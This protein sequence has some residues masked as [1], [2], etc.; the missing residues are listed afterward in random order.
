ME[1]IQVFMEEDSVLTSDIET[2]VIATQQ[3]EEDTLHRWKNAHHLTTDGNGL[4][5][6][7]GALVVVGNNDLRRGV[8]RLFHD[9]TTAGHPGITKTTQLISEYY[10]WPGMKDFITHYIKGCATCQ[11]SKV[12]THPNK[13]QIS[14]VTATP[15]ALPFETVAMDFIVKL[16]ESEG[17][18]TILTITD[19]DCTKAAIFIPCNETIDTPELAKLYAVHIFP[20]YGIPK[21]IISDRDP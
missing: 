1:D 18:D 7:D 6:H 12:N 10:W 21:K 4:W 16:P 20:H 14:P 5:W 3:E 2:S 11:M 17:K 8:L 9:A 15:G 13:P 19:H